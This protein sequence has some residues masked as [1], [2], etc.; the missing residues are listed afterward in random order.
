MTPNMLPVHVAGFTWTAALVGLLNLLIGGALVAV[1][2]S[3]PRLKELAIRQRRGDMEDFRTRISDLERRVDQA[4]E[5][6][7]I[8]KDSATIVR[9]Q[10][11]SMQ[12]A[13]ELVA[14]ELERADPDNPVLKQAR[15]LIA[16]AATSDMG[17]GTAMRQIAQ[18]KGTRE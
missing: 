7:G 1:I 17:I 10:M 3:W 9:M 14:G 2:K 6:A 18:L 4:N 15:R 16:Q 12:A 8:A 11:V 13:F 5:A